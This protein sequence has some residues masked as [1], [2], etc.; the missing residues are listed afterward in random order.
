VF[1]GFRHQMND[2]FQYAAFARQARDGSGLLMENPFTAEEQR[3]SYL[4]PFLWA[5][6]VAA[7]ATGASIP[8]V[9]EVFRLAGGVLYVLAFWRLAGHYV[10]EERRRLL[11]TALFA[12]GGGL[13]WI[14]TLLVPV[15]P[16]LAPLEGAYE[17]FWNWSA[18]G[19]MA[20]PNW[21]WPAATFLL[22]CEIELSRP[23][24]ADLL[25]LV[26]LAL[27]WFLHPY[28]GMVAY[29]AFGLVPAVP[30]AAAFAARRRPAWALLLR[31]RLR[32]A[33]VAV[34]AFV[35]VAA[36]L[37]WAR[38]EPVFAITSERGFSYTDRFSLWWYP[39]SYGLLLPLGAVGLRALAG[40]E[41]PRRDLLLAWLVAAFVLSVNPF[42]AGVKFQYL[43]FPPLALLAGI[44]LLRLWDGSGRAR[45]LLAVPRVRVALGLLLFLNAPIALARR[46]ATPDTIPGLY[47][48]GAE[49]DAMRWLGDQ[50]QG[51]VMSAFWSGARL[52]WLAG[53]KVYLG[54]WFLTPSANRK[55][56]DMLRFF[57]PRAPTPAK[58][59][60]LEQSRIRYVYVGPLERNLGSVDPDLPLTKIYDERG[61]QIYRVLDRE[62]TS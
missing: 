22:A 27:V 3:P 40:E 60:I 41:S 2:H 6:G 15:V 9:W 57:S 5:V 21:T 14:A 59:S 30:V 16:P 24:G 42:Y 35:P 4:L 11:V 19:S 18:F 8:A 25:L 23:P 61:V 31:R 26:L 43:V 44:G 34:A 20:L 13:D 7:R 47:M 52:P 12:A 36:Y 33:L 38:G 62:G 37:L 51:V 56:Q 1:L 50:P 46:P 17:Q 55:A 54:H 48:N 45:R 39:L 28:T 58:R 10:R 29:L 32:P 53:K 49:I